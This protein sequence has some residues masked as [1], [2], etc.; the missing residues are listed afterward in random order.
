MGTNITKKAQ[1]K[2]RKERVAQHIKKRI[3]QQ[4]LTLSK[5]KK[6]LPTKLRQFRSRRSTIAR[7]LQMEKSISPPNF[8]KINLLRAERSRISWA[9]RRIKPQL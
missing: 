3:A 2:R 5:H 4:S 8:K 1:Q 7:L 6:S 9:I